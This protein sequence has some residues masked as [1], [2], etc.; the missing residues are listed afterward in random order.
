MKKL[1]IGIQHFGKLRQSGYLYV[2]KTRLVHQLV[3]EGQYYF[4]ARPRRFGKS[5][6]VSTLKALFEGQ[7]ELFDGLWI[8][9]HWDWGQEHAVLHFAFN[10]MDYRADSLQTVLQERLAET[11]A[12]FGITLNSTG[13]GGQFRELI[14]TLGKERPV[15]V[16]VDEYD[17]PIVDYI[18]NLEQANAN[19]EVLR[20]F[21]SVL[22]EADPYLRLVFLTGV[23][24]FSKVSIFSDLNNLE[25]ISLSAAFNNIVGYTQAEL[26]AYF[27]DRL[28]TLAKQLQLTQEALLDEIKRWYNGYSWT[29]PD[30]VYNPFSILNFMKQGRFQNFWFATGTP[31][32]LIRLMQEGYHFRLDGLTVSGTLLDFFD[33]ASP[34]YR[35]VLFQTGYLTIK[36]QPHYNIYTLGYPNKE[37]EDALLQYLVGAY[38]YRSRGDSAPMAVQLQ[39]ALRAGRTDQFVSILNSLFSGIPERIFRQR[40]EAA[41]HAIVYTSMQLMGFYIEAEVSTGDGYLDA[42]VKTPDTIYVIEFKYGHPAE[43]AIAQI[44]E[45]GYAERYRHE[46]R[47]V[48]LLGISFGRETK[49]ILDWA[50]EDL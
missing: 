28:P 25:D 47:P 21:Y 1:P 49:G 34:D 5:L 6:L 20:S 15:V 12:N 14:I 48:R 44:R 42:L 9:D 19:R 22:K 46:G 32:F 29:G 7:R 33:V 13:I 35:S 18:D 36:D 3:T 41:Y 43:R 26:E 40:N 45:R 2:D 37:V 38:S 23:S 11:A 16:L 8:A 27:A 24:K 4:L 50:E 31:T 10:S 17:K 39:E 30:R